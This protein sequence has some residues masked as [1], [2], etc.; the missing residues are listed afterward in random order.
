MENNITIGLFGTCGDTTW[1]KDFINIYNELKINYYN[2]QKDD[3]KIEDAEL[4]ADHL[5]NDDIV[6][7]PVT[8][9]TYGLGSLGEV[10]FSILQAIKLNEKRYFIVLIDKDVS[11]VPKEHYDERTAKESIK[12]RALIKQH[13]NKLDM[14]NVYFVSTM[15]EM[16]H[17]SIELYKI[18][19]RLRE[20]RSYTVNYLK[21]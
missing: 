5:T 8:N 12:M 17:L 16:Q 10:G 21:H 14:P 1:R 13:L 15:D 11:N 19:L 2:P 18:Q 20:L 3:W 7:F 4:E 6:L 9:E